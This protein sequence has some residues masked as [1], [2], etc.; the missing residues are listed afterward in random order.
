MGTVLGSPKYRGPALVAPE[1]LMADSARNIGTRFRLG[2]PTA[3]FGGRGKPVC[4][5][6][7][8]SHVS[9]VFFLIFETFSKEG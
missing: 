4:R 8:I 7:F 5:G 6:D 2:R 3:T 1:P 9:N